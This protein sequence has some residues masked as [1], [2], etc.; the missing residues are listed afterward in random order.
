[1]STILMGRDAPPAGEEQGRDPLLEAAGFG[2]RGGDVESIA[3]GDCR[4]P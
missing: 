3:V 1:M 4:S 2:P